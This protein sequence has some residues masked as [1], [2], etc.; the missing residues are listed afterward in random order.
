MIVFPFYVAFVVAC[1]NTQKAGRLTQK[2]T[3]S[4][5]SRSEIHHAQLFH[6][7]LRHARRLPI[8]ITHDVS[9]EL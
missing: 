8:P 5:V 6:I 1:E 4:A 3:P 7:A 9:F 2:D